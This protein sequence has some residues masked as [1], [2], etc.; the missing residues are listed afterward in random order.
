MLYEK[1]ISNFVLFK[2]A[3]LFVEMLALVGL[4]IL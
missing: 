4:V 2:V 1:F 3:Q